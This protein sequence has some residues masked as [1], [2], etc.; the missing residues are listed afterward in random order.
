MTTLL[1][2]LDGWGYRESSYGNAILQASTPIYDSLCSSSLKLLLKADGS[3]VGLQEG[4]C[5]NSEVG[6]MTL[7]TGRPP[8][9]PLKKIRDSLALFSPCLSKTLKPFLHKESQRI[10]LVGIFSQ[11]GVHG[12]DTLTYL[13]CEYL[14]H[15]FPHAIVLH[16]ISDGRDE[17]YGRLS[18]R[19]EELN[20]FLRERPKI[21]CASIS[22][23]FYAMDRDHHEERTE[24]FVQALQGR[25][26]KAASLFKEAVGELKSLPNASEEF[27]EP[28]IESGYQG[29]RPDDLIV[30]LNYRVDRARQWFLSLATRR[31]DLHY[32][33]TV[34]LQI[35]VD[36]QVF[37]KERKREHTLTEQLAGRGV[38]Q[39]RVT[40]SEKL[41]HITYYFDGKQSQD[42]L[43]YDL[44]I[45]PS[46]K[47][48]SWASDPQMHAFE[49]ASIVSKALREKSHDFIL[50]NFPNADLVGHSGDLGA[51]IQACQ[52]LDS[53]LGL[54]KNSLDATDHCFVTAD[55]G[56]CE[57]MLTDDGFPH[58]AHT[59]SLVPFLYLGPWQS[60]HR[61]SAQSALGA[62]AQIGQVS[63]TVLE[64]F[65][66][67]RPQE[68]LPSL[69]SQC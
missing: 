1:V 23:R 36:Y 6:H 14:L 45:I 44:E 35:R 60:T 2:I 15:Y 16:L 47:V 50:V 59:R 8:E 38:S 26:R 33:S 56:N 57:Q 22:G 46:P 12:L 66:V 40:E 54:L 48:L 63:A 58:T 65:S 20:A 68:W 13:W 69:W 34:D 3:A 24:R 53:A 11:G 67:Q 5:G 51:S 52:T 64:T 19:L 37:V 17:P 25:G 7:G 21:S 4:F 41:P 30:N 28:M 32:F 9:S 10:H 42:K 39:L 43:H 27:L 29:L 18:M 55:H 61:L 62:E 31:E 49:L